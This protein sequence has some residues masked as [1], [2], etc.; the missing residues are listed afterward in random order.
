MT[1]RL[2]P[3]TLRRL[4]QL[5]KVTERSKAWLAA[6]AVKDYLEVNEWQTRAIHAAVKK[7]DG[8]KAKFFDHDKVGEWLDTWGT[9]REH[10]LER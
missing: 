7:A 1:L 6:Q 2:D 4:D 8:R 3:A 10:E 5:A 9:D